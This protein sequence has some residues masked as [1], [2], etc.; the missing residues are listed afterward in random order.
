MNY[1]AKVTI[2]E[3]GLKEYLSQYYSEDEL[4]DMDLNDELVEALNGELSNF[5]TDYSVVGK[6]SIVIEG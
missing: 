5:F 3:E 1:T 4:E 2:S 6:N